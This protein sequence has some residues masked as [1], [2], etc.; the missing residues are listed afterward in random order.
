MADIAH[1]TF[2]SIFVEARTAAFG[3]LVPVSAIFAGF[4]WPV[5]ALAADPALI[6]FTNG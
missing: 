6:S 1:W 4:H 5:T 3:R 2:P